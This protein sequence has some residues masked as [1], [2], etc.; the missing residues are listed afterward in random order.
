MIKAISTLIFLLYS[1]NSFADIGLYQLEIEDK[2]RNR[3][4]STF[5][6]YPSSEKTK[7][8]FAENIAFYGFSAS[9]DSSVSKDKLPLYILAHGTSGNWKNTTWLAKELSENAIVVSANFPDYTTGQASPESVLKPWNQAKDISFLIDAI[10][11]GPYGQY[12][13]QN[14][15]A[16][17]GHSLGGYTAMALSGAI[18]DLK[19]YHAFCKINTDKSCHYFKAALEKLTAPNIEEAKQSV[20]DKRVKAAIAIAPGFAE[21]MTQNSLKN[22]KTPMLI[23]SA[24]NDL[25]VPSKT[26]LSNIPRNINQYLIKEASH[27]S[28][29]QV[30]KPNAKIILAEDGAEFVC[31]DG[32][33]KARPDIH[34]ETLQQIKLFLSKHVL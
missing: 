21:S 20:Y 19:K 5:I 15:I 12:I 18:I 3:L 8:T 32:G 1:L 25:N 23:I 30:C 14:K 4:L 29:L 13:D 27:F 6:F 17:I 2:T 24:E 7:K 10:I 16:V 33:K 11:A 31:E 28:F 9:E 26:H 22:S 34:K